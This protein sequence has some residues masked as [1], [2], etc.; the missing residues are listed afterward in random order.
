MSDWDRPGPRTTLAHRTALGHG[1]ALAHGTRPPWPTG[2]PWPLRRG[3][4]RDL[5]MSDWDRVFGAG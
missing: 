4:T 1:T 3:K 2:P 5:S